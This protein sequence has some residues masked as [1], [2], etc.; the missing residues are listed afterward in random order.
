MRVSAGAG[1]SYCK[2]N[3]L[4][5]SVLSMLGDMRR[6]VLDELVQRGFIPPHTLADANRNSG[7]HSVVLAALAA[8]LYPHVAFRP[9]STALCSLLRVC[10][11]LCVCSECARAL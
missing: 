4:S 5:S 11:C 8:G 10:A 6:Q 9:E 3:Y 1:W 2:S 7:D